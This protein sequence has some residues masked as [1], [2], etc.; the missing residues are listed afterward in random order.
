[1]KKNKNQKEANI[2]NQ[3]IIQIKKILV[4]KTFKINIIKEFLKYKFFY[5][6]KLR[7]FLS[8]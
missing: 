2:N 3:K 1:M 5:Y 8:V 7:I 6:I 4:F